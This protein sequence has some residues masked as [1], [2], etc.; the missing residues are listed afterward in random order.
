MFK[1]GDE[2]ECVDAAPANSPGCVNHGMAV[3]LIKGATYTVRELCISP[4]SGRSGV[5][6][7]EPETRWA[8]WGI[9][10]GAYWAVRFRKVERKS[11]SLSIEAFR[12]IQDGG[13]EEPKRTNQPAKRKE[14]AS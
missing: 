9:T 13:F 12:T 1:V 14:R 3:P 5:R 8:G 7:A 2:V 4:V 6:L 10:D 11:D